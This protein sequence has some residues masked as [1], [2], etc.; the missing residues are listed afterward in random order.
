M[1]AVDALQRTYKDLNDFGFG[2]DSA[3]RSVKYWSPIFGTV[4]RRISKQFETKG[5]RE[6]YT[7]YRKGIIR[8]RILDALIAG[9]SKEA[10]KIINAWNKANPTEAFLY[11]DIG[12][13]AIFDGSAALK[14]AFRRTS[15]PHS[16]AAGR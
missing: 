10:T 6:T 16:A 4:P 8:G 2:K 7:R 9:Q 12:V 14:S 1:K 3:L 15:Q 13:S 5:Q 11:E